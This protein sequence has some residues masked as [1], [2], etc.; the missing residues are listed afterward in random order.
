[1][2]AKPIAAL[3][4][5]LATVMAPAAVAQEKIKIGIIGP[6]SG[7]FAA[8]GVQFRQGIET[9]VA[10][11]GTKAGD[12]EIELIYRD[13][14]GTNPAVAKRLAEELIVKEKVSALGGFY[15]SPEGF[16]VASVINETK[17]PAVLFVSGA[18]PIVRQSPYFVRAGSTLWQEYI[19][20]AEWAVKKGHKRAYIAVADFAPGHDAQETFK[21]KF[22]ELG[23]QVVGEDRIPLNTV[24][25]APFAERI[26]N[27]NAE[28][29]NVFIP[30]GAPSVGFLKALAA[31]GIMQKMVVIGCAETDDADLHLFDESVVGYYSSL[32]YTIGLP[33]EENRKF[34]AKLNEKFPGAI[35]SYSMVNAH[36]G[37]HLLYKMVEAQKGKTTFD[38][39]A[40]MAAVKGYS[41]TSPRGPL[42]IEA[43]TREITLNMYIRRLE[44]VNGR[45]ENVVID[46]Y[47]AIKEP[48]PQR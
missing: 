48:A 22:T 42:K 33:H 29:V 13:T 21:G 28:V 20:P 34:K 11:N 32:Y 14:G 43:D 6:F 3:A 40:A 35:P 18:R 39:E 4:L 26:A 25:F 41:W 30:P 27:S 15:L 1:M 37:T 10:L 5:L 46:T 16:A 8:T 31:R 7:P 19:P 47:E 2:R 24:D 36:D 38:P 12:R 45:L 17:T 44:K 9:Y 23:G